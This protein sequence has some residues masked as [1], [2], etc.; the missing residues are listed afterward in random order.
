V[1]RP[2]V[3][4]KAASAQQQILLT[5]EL[6]PVSGNESWDNRIVE[7]LRLL[8]PILNRLHLNPEADCFYEQLSGGLLWTDELPDLTGVPRETFEAFHAL[9]SV[10]WYRTA[11]IL[12]E[13][14]DRGRA[15]WPE[16]ER[17]FPGWSG[18]EKANQAERLWL[19]AQRLFPH[20]PG[21]APYRRS[22]ELRKKCELKAKAAEEIDKLFDR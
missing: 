9:R 2:R 6:T 19:Q 14:K 15:L 20:W 22:R 8:A 18:T 17:L 3:E 10:L 13:G 7:N 1:K 4:R 21:F 12:G 16:M 11:L 5:L